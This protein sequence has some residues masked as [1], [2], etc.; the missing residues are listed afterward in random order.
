LLVRPAAW[1]L[2]RVPARAREETCARRSF[3]AALVSKTVPPPVFDADR[4]L[5]EVDEWGKKRK[6]E[7]FQE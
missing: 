4:H 2:L 3:R 6:R 7:Q 1:L 5:R